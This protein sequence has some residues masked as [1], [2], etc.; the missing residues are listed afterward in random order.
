MMEVNI[1]RNIKV[2]DTVYIGGWDDVIIERVVRK[3][4][5]DSYVGTMFGNS[6]TKVKFIYNIL[7]FDNNEFTEDYNTISESDPRAQELKN[8]KERMIENLISKVLPG[9]K[10]NVA[11]IKLVKAVYNEIMKNKEM[12]LE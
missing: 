5:E 8:A 2:G 10:K 9:K 7:Y 4:K 6:D 1:K 11:N 12:Y 3:I